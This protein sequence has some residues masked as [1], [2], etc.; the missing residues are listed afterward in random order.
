MARVLRFAVLAAGLA[1]GVFSLA[2]ARRGA[3]YALGGS[4][5]VDSPPGGGTR[6]M[7]ALP[8]D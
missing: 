4:L 2:V 1:L 6:V 3:G 5:V 8:C 7:A